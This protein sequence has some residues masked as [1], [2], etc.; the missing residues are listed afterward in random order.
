MIDIPR[1][2]ELATSAGVAT[3][4][5]VLE[6]NAIPEQTT[7]ECGPI[8]KAG[9]GSSVQA[10]I[11]FVATHPGLKADAP[12]PVTIDGHEGQS[13]DFTVAA[14]WDKL[15]TNTDP[16]EPAVLMLTDTGV[17]PGRALAYTADHRVRWDVI[18]VDGQTVIIEFDGSSFGDTFASSVAA[19]QPIVD[20]IRFQPAN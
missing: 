16:V 10:F 7:S 19:A 20:S 4:I 6:M 5:E 1:S 13:I 18:D 8:A 14:S 17:P 2:Y 3:P 15:C 12:V 11:D 9:A